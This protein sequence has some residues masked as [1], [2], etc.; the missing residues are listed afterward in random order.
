MDETKLREIKL[1]LDG[2]TEEERREIFAYLRGQFSIHQLEQEFN[3]PA[4]M[5]LE[6]IRRSDDIT[7]RGIRGIIAE[8]AF[9]EYVLHPIRPAGWEEVP[10]AANMPYDFHIMDGVGEVRIQVKLQRKLKGRPMH[11]HETR[12]SLVGKI[13]PM[14]MVETQ[15]TRSG[16]DADGKKTR[17]YR[18]GEFDI[19]AVSLSPSSNSWRQFLFTVGNWLLEKDKEQGA[20]ATYQPVPMLEDIARFEGLWTTDITECIRWFRGGEGKRISAPE[21]VNF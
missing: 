5:I 8:L 12:K 6:A 13:I 21:L 14:W 17:P 4:E 3:I 19:L 18:Y 9:A 20:I 7:Q 16:E 2:A 1:L 15:K 10:M 11:F